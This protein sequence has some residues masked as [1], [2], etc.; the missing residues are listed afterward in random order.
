MSS[1]AEE[2][3]KQDEMREDIILNTLIK[4]VYYRDTVMS[5]LKP[6]FFMDDQN[7]KLFIAIHKLVVKDKIQKLDK[8][9]ILLKYQDKSHLDYLFGEDEYPNENIDFLIKE[10]ESWGK[11][12]ALKESVLEASDII[13]EKKDTSIIGNLIR[14]ALAFSFDKNL[15]LNFVADI[16]RRFDYYNKSE[17]KIATKYKMLDYY[18]N[19]GLQKKTLT[20]GAG[21]SGLGKTLLGTN[22]STNF[23]K[24]GLSGV[25]L[26]LE[27]AEELIARRIDSVLT[28][29]PYH[30]L[31]QKRKEV[32]KFFKDFKGGNIHIKEYPP[33]KASCVNIRTYLKEL[34]LL[35]KFKPDFLIVDYIQL[36][37]PN[38]EKVGG[39]SYDKYKDIAEELRELAVELD[40]PVITF[41]QVQ[42]EGYS[43]SN[44]S[45]THIADSIGIV[46]TADLIIGMTQTVEE[47]E[48]SEQTWRIIKNRLGRKG[49]SFQVKQESTLLKFVQQISEE[50]QHLLDA[51][52]AK[53]Q[54]K[55]NNQD[56]GEE[57][58][59]IEDSEKEEIGEVDEYADFIETTIENEDKTGKYESFN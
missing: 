45:S 7:E 32:M 30:D 9:T 18:T 42:R 38:H 26:T 58:D 36:M 25:Y 54:W 3:F 52:E 24:Q 19:G 55:E 39:G 10:T 20:I 56:D 5:H 51:Y 57:E 46:N 33:S 34:E 21:S 23:I 8:K 49:V 2:N 13:C 37:K 50:E 47:E 27:L 14:K 59:I 28:K 31:P 1:T 16:K 43:N 44:L 4:N 41:S 11:E 22:L 6:I 40:I 17:E 15:G 53:Q 29:V 35:E 48:L 12:Q